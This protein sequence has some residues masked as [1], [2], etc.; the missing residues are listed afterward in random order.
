MSSICQAWTRVSGGVAAWTAENEVAMVVDH[1]G[2]QEKF[3]KSLHWPVPFGAACACC[4]PMNANRTGLSSLATGFELANNA[5]AAQRQGM[6]GDPAWPPAG[7]LWQ[8]LA[9]PS[10]SDEAR[11]RRSQETGCQH[12]VGR[13]VLVL[14]QRPHGGHQRLDRLRPAPG[15]QDIAGL[16]RAQRHAGAAGHHLRGRPRRHPRRACSRFW[17]RSRPAPSRSRRRSRTST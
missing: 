15:A 12:H 14:A 1:G 17:R 8:R 16:D 11:V 9:D 3:R 4:A 13:P 5:Q 7:N 2:G 10:R 6:A